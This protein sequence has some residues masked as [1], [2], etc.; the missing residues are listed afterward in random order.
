LN[1]SLLTA[2]LEAILSKTSRNMALLTAGLRLLKVRLPPDL[3]TSLAT[4]VARAQAQQPDLTISGAVRM[5]L[6][7]GIAADAGSPLDL[8]AAAYEEGYF[9]GHGAAVRAHQEALHGAKAKL[10]AQT[11]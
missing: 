4:F 2:N 9:D 10:A 5:L 8:K 7:V 3:A 11:A 1:V 6:R